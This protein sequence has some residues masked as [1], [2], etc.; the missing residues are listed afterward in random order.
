MHALSERYVFYS[1]IQ[2][3]LFHNVFKIY[4]FQWILHIS[5]VFAYLFHFSFLELL[6]SK[7]DFVCLHLCLDILLNKTNNSVIRLMNYDEE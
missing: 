1:D 5:S 2:V 6:K 3:V 7:L 4:C